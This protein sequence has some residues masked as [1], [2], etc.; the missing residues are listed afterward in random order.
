MNPVVRDEGFVLR[1]DPWSNTSRRVLWLLRRHGRTATLLR[2]ALRPKSFLLGQCDLFYRCEVCFYRR[3][4]GDTHAVRECFPLDPHPAL[5]RDWRACAAASWL[6]ALAA[7]SLPPAAQ[8]TPRAYAGMRLALDALDGGADARAVQHWFEL[9]WLD[10]LGFAPRLDRCVCGRVP[11]AGA[12]FVPDRGGLLCGRCRAAPRAG[13]AHAL[14]ADALALLRAWQRAPEPRA[15]APVR[16]T[17]GQTAAMNAALAAFLRH[18][19]EDPLD[20]RTAL[21]ETLTWSPPSSSSSS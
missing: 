6:A 17:P 8:A 18:H 21:D 12:V 7:R 14:P 16:R 3:P 13:R 11:D 19:L 20:E 15:L 10:A 1:M 5:R 4:R 2:G 9:Q